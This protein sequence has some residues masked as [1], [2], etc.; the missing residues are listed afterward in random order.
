MASWIADGMKVFYLN[1]TEGD[2]GIDRSG[3]PANAPGTEGDPDLRTHHVRRAEQEHAAQAL[4]VT[5]VDFLGHR[6]GLVAASASLRRELAD[7]I[8]GIQPLRVLAPTPVWNLD[9]PS[10]CHPDHLA[11]GVAACSAVFLD[12]R[13]PNAPPELADPSLVP[14]EVKELWLMS[15]GS[16]NCAVDITAQLEVKRQAVLAHA[17]QLADTDAWWTNMRRWAAECA[18]RWGLPD[19]R[20]AEEFR[21]IHLD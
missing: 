6:D 20:F 18:S 16:P 12:A 19:G 9:V 7:A 15:D 21:L 1:V 8:R 2:A 10:A 5:S 11:V 13:N 17:S 3:A 14:H 4:G